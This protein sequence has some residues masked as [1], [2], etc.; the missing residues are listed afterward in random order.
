[1]INIKNNLRIEREIVDH[2][3]SVVEEQKKNPA[4]KGFY[5]KIIFSLLDE[6]EI[7][8]NSIPNLIA[9]RGISSVRGIYVSSSE[10]EKLL[11]TLSIEKDALK[12][13]KKV[14]QEKQQK[15]KEIGLFTIISSKIFSDV[16]MKLRNLKFFTDMNDDLRKSNTP[17]LLTTYISMILFATVLSFILGIALGTLF[18]LSDRATLGIASFF[19]PVAV[20]F[21]FYVY[22]SSKVSGL[23]AKIDDELPFAI[24]HMAAISGSGVTPSQIFEIIVKSPDYPAVGG[25]M[26]KIVNQINFYGYSLI[27]SL[28]NIAKTTASKRLA[29]LFNGIASTLAS[30]GSLKDYLEKNSVDTLNDYKLRR[31]RYITIS[32]TYADIY[33]GLLIAAPLI[34]MLILVLVNILG[35]T[36]GGMTPETMGVIGIGGLVVINI[37]FL[38]FLEVSQPKG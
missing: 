30:G 37:G 24:I 33:T 11:E 27:N 12:S 29:E 10:K 6:L 22:P 8:N 28:K 18:I 36:I 26:R 17:L 23:K 13:I 35:G 34:F 38:V 15:E 16:S 31:R 1:M 5:N 19:L 7:L 14:S 3:N 20:F 25:E 4:L 32:E 2:L 9:E 21:G